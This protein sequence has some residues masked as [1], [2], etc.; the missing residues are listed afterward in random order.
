M[1]SKTPLYPSPRS[2]SLT[3]FDRDGGANDDEL[4]DLSVEELEAHLLVS[5]AELKA[6]RVKL[7]VIEARRKAAR[8]RQALANGKVEQKPTPDQNRDTGYMRKP[9]QV[10]DAAYTSVP[11]PMRTPA[12][13]SHNIE[14]YE[15]DRVSNHAPRSSYERN[16]G[17]PTARKSEMMDRKNFAQNHGP[18]SARKDSIDRLSKEPTVRL[19]SSLQEAYADFDDE[20]EY[21]KCSSHSSE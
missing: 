14:H 17:H 15:H 8:E 21:E 3:N 7:K 9:S 5:Q 19:S 20:H 13:Y 1:F 11:S 12:R 2:S 4:D 18:I 6:A 10:R 16:I